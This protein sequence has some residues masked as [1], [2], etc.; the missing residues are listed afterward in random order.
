MARHTTIAAV[1]FAVLVAGCGSN[2][3]ERVG[4]KH[5][6]GAHVLTILKPIDNAEE[7]GYF[8]GQVER[9][10][11]GRL[12]IRFVSSGYSKRADFEAATIRDMQHG[13]ADLSWAGSRVWD[14]FGARRL[15]ALAAPLLVDSLA[16]EQ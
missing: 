4:T 3:S 12:R 1:A 13:R 7:L 9:L 2:G 6:A 5:A 11:H 14:E 15:R 8:A 16:L 10:S